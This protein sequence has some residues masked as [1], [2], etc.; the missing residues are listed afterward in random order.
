MRALK[1][2][3][4]FSFFFFL[5]FLKNSIPSKVA[6]PRSAGIFA[7]S[8]LDELMTKILDAVKPT[9]RKFVN[10]AC[11]NKGGKGRRDWF[12]QVGY[13]GYGQHDIDN[14]ARVLSP[15]IWSTESPT[16]WSIG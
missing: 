4:F 14:T 6:D 9:L 10:D 13:V 5:S 7:A 8:T 11:C 2:S 1:G 12:I 3:L 15:L 16:T